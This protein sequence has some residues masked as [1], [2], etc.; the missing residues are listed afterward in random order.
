LLDEN[1]NI[2]LSDFGV[3]KCLSELSTYYSTTA[4]THTGGVGTVHW[5]APEVVAR[6]KYGRKADI[7]YVSVI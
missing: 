5:M 1:D 3:S 7:W 2:K 4:G 6:K